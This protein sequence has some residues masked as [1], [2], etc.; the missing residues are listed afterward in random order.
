M[1]K[2]S[3]CNVFGWD[4]AFNAM[5]LCSH[6]PDLA[7]D[8][9]MVFAEREDPFGKAP[10]NMNDRD[11][12]H[13]FSKP[14]VHGWALRR[15]WDENPSMMTPERIEEAYTHLARWT[16]WW[17]QYRTWEGASLPHYIHGFDSG[18][19]NSTIFDQ[20]T[21]LAAPDLAAYL[22]IQQEVLGDLAEALG[23]ETGAA[24]WRQ[25][26]TQTLASLLGEL[27]QDGE[28]VGRIRPSDT[29]V[30][31][32]S[33]IAC[34]PIVLGRRLPADVQKPLVNRIREHLTEWGLATEKPTS[35]KYRENSYWRGP[36]WA[37]PT[38]LAISGLA[39]IGE[40]DL[41][42]Q[43]ARGYIEMC[44]KSGFAE[45]FDPHTGAGHF[46]PAYTWTSSVFLILA[47]QYA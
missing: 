38:L 32:E 4:H 17:T 46:D 9:M 28:F 13:T 29:A 37:P 3:M 22:V 10:D 30:S 31:S 2:M 7:W 19:D 15:M 21:P 16:N 18:W 47:S 5:A 20:G 45:N 1:S 44:R 42:R 23:D 26:S 25:K 35:P 14:P 40:E 41:V 43:I 24:E 12:M 39:D 8:Q 34:M 36:I 27:W 6:D 11:I 33:L